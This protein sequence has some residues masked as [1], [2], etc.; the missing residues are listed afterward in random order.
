[1]IKFNFYRLFRTRLLWLTGL[2]LFPALLHAAGI[3]L[4]LGDSLSAGYGIPVERAWPSLLEKRL[5]EKHLDYTV[6]NE[7]ISGETTEGG[8][9]RLDELIDEYQPQIIIIAL[10]SNDGLRRYALDSIREN[11]I[12]MVQNAQ[13]NHAQVL[14]VGNR[15]PPTYGKYAAQ[16]HALYPEIAKKMKVKHIDFLLDGVALKSKYLLD[17]R[18]HPNVAAQPILLDNIWQELKRMLR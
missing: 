5:A 7:S 14:L 2:I 10:G 8:L 18:I 13:D 11:L 15:I 3:I 12:A 6:I 16:F 9:A 1:M 4:V 17:D